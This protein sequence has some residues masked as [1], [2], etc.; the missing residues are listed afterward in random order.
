MELP[1]TLVKIL[2]R[3]GLGADYVVDVILKS[4]N[5]D[6]EDYSAAHAELAIKMFK[7]GVRF[8]EENNIIQASEKLYKAIEE[9]IKALAIAKN[10]EEAKIALD[11]GRWT[12]S[13][14]DKAARKLGDIIWRAWTEA[15]FLHVNGFHETRIDIDDVKA[16][17]KF[18]ENAINK[19][20]LR[21]Q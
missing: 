16:R 1:E 9:T 10:L 19:L 3:R 21:D 8:L 15:Y 18:I 12:V 17:L 6:P 11:K 4:I 2:E 7:E 5:A 20:N 14:L 13:L